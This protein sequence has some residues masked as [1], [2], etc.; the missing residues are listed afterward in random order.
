MQKTVLNVGANGRFGR[1]MANAFHQKGWA[2]KLFARTKPTHSLFP[3]DYIQGDALNGEAL[4]DAA[5]DC[6]I[7]VNALSPPYSQWSTRIPQFT[8]NIIAA[9]RASGATI[10]VPGNVYNF[11][12]NMPEHLTENTPQTSTGKLGKIR[13]AMEEDYAQAVEHGVQTIIMRAG[14]FIERKVTGNWFDSQVISKIDK[15]RITYPGPMNC[16][17]SWAYLPDMARAFVE[18]AEQRDKL[19]NFETIGFPGYELTG[20]ELT[21]SLEEVAKRRLKVSGMPWQAV[22][23]LSIFRPDIRG[24]VEMSYLWR[25][26][27]RI[28]GKK[29][30]DI[31]PSFIETPIL[32]ALRDSISERIDVAAIEP[33]KL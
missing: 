9:A 25:Q 30:F 28:D 22:K 26:P 2:L 29:F 12:E 19:S 10:L 14:D 8:K 15:G 3:Y 4:V 31:L 23:M 7:I 20:A 13:T 6:A 5:E 27:H 32:T 16:K 18:V 17:H 33:I 21:L 1:A 11:G 24:V